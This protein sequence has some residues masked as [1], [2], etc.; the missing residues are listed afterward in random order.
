MPTARTATFANATVIDLTADNQTAN[1]ALVAPPATHTI[2]GTVTAGGGLDGA[3][4]YVVRRGQLGLRRQ[5]HDRR[6]RAPTASACPGLTTS[7]ASRPTDAGYPDQAYGPDGD[8]RQRHGHRPHGRQPDRR[9]RPGRARRSTHTIS[10]TV[11][12]AGSGLD[13]AIVYVFDAGS[14]AYVGNTTTAG[15][16][17]Y[18]LSLPP[19]H[20]KLWIQTN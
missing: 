8:L 20:Y 10:G 11:T 9:R 12:A 3:I 18:S 14:S 7:C 4:V 6:R 19:A 16:G 5:H 15:G 13:G 1:V 2:S 17:A